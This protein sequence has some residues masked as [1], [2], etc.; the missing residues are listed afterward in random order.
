MSGRRA[1]SPRISTGAEGY[2]VIDWDKVEKTV[3]LRSPIYPARY[4]VAVF[5]LGQSSRN[6]M[7]VWLLDRLEDEVHRSRLKSLGYDMLPRVDARTVYLPF[8][9]AEVAE[10]VKAKLGTDKFDWRSEETT[11]EDYYFG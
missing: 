11:P 4:R 8:S 6:G 2:T 9:K 10:Y 5:T 3:L 7:P 1:V